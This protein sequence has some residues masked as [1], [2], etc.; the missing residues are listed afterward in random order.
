MQESVSGHATLS[1]S[2][3][4]PGSVCRSD[5]RVNKDRVSPFGWCGL[6]T[7]RILLSVCW[8]WTLATRPTAQGELNARGR[9]GRSR[10]RGRRI[11]IIA[12]HE[13]ISSPEQYLHKNLLYGLRELQMHYLVEHM[14][15]LMPGIAS[16][17]IHSHPTLP[18]CRKLV[19]HGKLLVLYLYVSTETDAVAPRRSPLTLLKLELLI[20]PQKQV[21]G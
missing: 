9:A 19:S 12:I 17:L 20:L 4:C 2:S 8:V 16:A 11:A 6:I 10:G 15:P 5:R 3:P 18:P 7:V 13:L 21:R 1:P 14:Q